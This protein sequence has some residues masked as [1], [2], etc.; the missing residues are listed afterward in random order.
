MLSETSRRQV[1]PLNHHWKYRETFDESFIDPNY[2][3]GPWVMVNIPHTNKEL[4]YSY[5]DEKSYQFVSTYRKTFTVDSVL[6]NERIFADFG[7]VMAY[8]EV[9]LNGQFLGSHKGGYTPFSVDLT[10]QIDLDRE[11]TMVVKVDSRERDDIPPFGHMI[12]YLCYGGIYRDVSLRI[13]DPLHIKN[14]F[15]KPQKVL[16]QE[17]ELETSVFVV[18]T[19]GEAADVVLEIKLS[20]DKKPIAAA[21][22]RVTL[23]A[24]TEM[25]FDVYLRNLGGVELWDIQSPHLYELEVCLKRQDQLTDT[26]TTRVGFREAVVKPDGFYLNGEKVM[27]RGLNRHQSFPYVGYAMPKRVQRKDADILKYELG[28][29][30]V[31]TSHYPQSNHFLDRCDEIGLLVFEEIPGW[32]YIGDNE[33]QEVAKNNVREMIERDWNHPSIFLWG[34]R[35]NESL[36][37]HDF[38]KETNRIA[39]ELDPTRQTGGVRYLEKSEFLED[40]YTMNDFIHSGGEIRLRDPRQ[41]TGTEEYVP[42][43]V[44][45]FNGHMYPTKRFDQEERVVEHAMRHLRVQD[46]AARDPHIAAAIGWC[47]FDYNTHY[48]FGSGDRI[49][50]HGVMDMFRIPK[51]AAHVYASQMDPRER[52]VLEPAT[53]WSRGDRSVGGVLPLVIFTNCDAVEVLVQ[54]ESIGTY[55]PRSEEFPGVPHAP[56]MITEI[57]SS[58]EWGSAW[59]SVEFVGYLDGKKVASKAFT[60]DAVPTR[61][62]AEADDDQL[63]ADGIDATRIVFKLVDQVGNPLS[64]TTEAV[65]IEVEGE[66]TLIGPSVS[67]LVGGVL[68]VWV[69]T[70]ETAGEIRVKARTNSQVARP[71][72]ITTK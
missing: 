68:G 66:G 11:N 37:N 3:D 53:L 1:L 48:D 47:A 30:V 10:D 36:D 14:V 4:P 31:R 35:I 46:A 28:L 44:C 5:F 60:K 12:D 40:V 64:Y 41:V 58:G 63:D 17:K 55:Y 69:K 42:Y 9:Y 38:Y 23:P 13:V 22:R 7:A 24:D 25:A 62:T 43:M 67:A 20:K 52:V 70:T 6:H 8:A 65:Q 71:V 26:Y 2:D 33:W 27:L 56:V 45:E 61:L 72:V 32:Q 34:V 39:R 54:G 50:H 29:N 51:M 57:P 59:P 16:Y 49:C 19:T 18:N 21:N 15:A